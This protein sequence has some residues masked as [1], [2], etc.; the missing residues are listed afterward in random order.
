MEDKADLHKHLLAMQGK[1]YP[2]YRDIAG[3]YN[4][5]WFTLRIDHVQ[6]DPF[7][8]P[9]RI[10]LRSTPRKINL[11]AWAYHSSERAISTA[12][13]L[14][15][16]FA[17]ALHRLGPHHLGSGKSGLLAVDEP[18]QE[19]LA[20]TSCSVH[21]GEVEMRLVV[22]LPASGRRILGREAADLLCVQLPEVAASALVLRPEAV[23]KLRA[24]VETVEDADALRTQ[25]GEHHLV[26]FVGD[27]SVLPRASGVSS[28]PLHGPQVVPFTAP[29]GLAVTLMRPHAGP[30]RGLGIPEGVTLI[31][32]GGF[33]GKST[34]LKALSLGVYNHVPGDGREWVV[35]HPQTSAIRAEDGRRICGVNISGFI[36]TLPGD[37]RT[38]RFFTDNASGS[39]SQA[40]NIVEA[41]E[42]GTNLLLID[43]D[44]SATNF[45][46]RDKRMQALVVKKHEPIT[47]FIDRVRE[48]YERHG[49]SS[50]LVLGGSGDY[51]DV[52]DTVLAMEEYHCRD[53]TSMARQVASAF[54]TGREVEVLSDFPTVFPR[55]LNPESIDPTRNGRAKVRARDTDEIS[56][57]KEEIDLSGLSQIVSLSQTRTIGVL[58]HWVA[59]RFLDGHRSLWEALQ[60][61]YGQLAEE[62]LDVLSP[63]YPV[64]DFALPRLLETGA[65]LN[66]LRSLQLMGD[67]VRNDPRQ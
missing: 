31:V 64:G 33:H 15:R 42:L 12:D 53:V 38:N 61:A 26:A 57:G 48:I 23:V 66:R 22:G 10:T 55:V 67:A 4:F 24:H 1:P 6:G 46:I 7:A 20:R 60:L 40:A 5:Q 21:D 25:L 62:G 17:L 47:P 63:G 56:F 32:G 39:T 11:P 58:L 16:Q 52:A 28:Q 43:E 44:T 50:I 65:A 59:Y 9:S 41:L 36:G 51:L 8:A 45:M 2:V 37:K 14:T 49:V 35:T 54:P 3:S 18:G 27:G 13:W 30:I 34:L 29:E 19:V